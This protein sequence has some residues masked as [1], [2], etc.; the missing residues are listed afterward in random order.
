[1]RAGARVAAA[2][3]Y[4][5][6]SARQFAGF[7]HLL[8]PAT[9][10]QVPRHVW[11][12]VHEACT[13]AGAAESRVIESVTAF[14]NAAIITEAIAGAL[15]KPDK[16]EDV[17]DYAHGRWSYSPGNLSIYYHGSVA[18]DI[19]AAKAAGFCDGWKIF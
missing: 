8:S 16:A 17:F 15:A 13:S 3:F 14:G 9:K 7:W 10:R 11:V 1:M 2:R 5:L 4:R 19:A 6:Y 12:K 18:A